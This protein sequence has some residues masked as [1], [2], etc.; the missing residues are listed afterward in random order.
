MSKK[1]SYINQDFKM[2]FNGT[3]IDKEL[4]ILSEFFHN[5]EE[6]TH[7]ITKLKLNVKEEDK[8]M[9]DRMTKVSDGH[10]ENIQVELYLDEIKYI[11]GTVKEV[12]EAQYNS[13]GFD[14]VLTL[15]S[16]SEILDRVNTFRV[17]QLKDITYLDVIEDILSRYN[18]NNSEEISLLGIEENRTEIYRNIKGGLLIQFNETDWEFLVRIASHLGMVMTNMEGGAILLGFPKSVDRDFT[19]DSERANKTSIVDYKNNRSTKLLTPEALM[20]GKNIYTDNLELGTV[21]SGELRLEEERFVS[22]V[23][24]VENRR[25][26]PFIENDKIQ[27]V[28]I[29]GKVLALPMSSENNVAIIKVDLSGGI[30]KIAKRYEEMYRLGN[31]EKVNLIKC[32]KDYF[33]K[34][35]QEGGQSG[36]RFNFPYTT[37]YSQTNTGY[38][39]TPEKDDVVAVNFM[40]S[41]E[42][43]GYVC[44]AVNNQGNLRFSNPYER[45]Y[46]TKHKDEIQ[47]DFRLRTAAFREYIKDNYKIYSENLLHTE[48]KEI[49]VMNVAETRETFKPTNIHLKTEK[50]EEKIIEAKSIIDSKDET[51]T[52]LNQDI[53]KLTHQ[54][55]TSEYQVKTKKNQIGSLEEKV[56]TKN[57][58]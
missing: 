41:L 53:D 37:P 4:Y 22:E 25:N 45:N 2:I 30:R 36:E 16:K 26:Y 18:K 21:I 48:A 52:T 20:S 32:F 11:I 50:Y 6:N 24:I 9:F 43:N 55:T 1:K 23:L 40:S 29:E 35:E 47:Y 39:C 57:I 7:S 54:A 17:Y 14:F 33:K 5:F 19:L 3:E 38:F 51:I 28:M 13:D 49:L 27:G 42:F 56:D 10:Y 46:T 12:G 31:G 15:V 8:R 34:A 58:S 44:Y